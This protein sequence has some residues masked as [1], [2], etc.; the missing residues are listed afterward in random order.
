MTSREKRLGLR[1][2]QIGQHSELDIIQENMHVFIIYVVT[3]RQAV[4]E[5]GGSVWY[6]CVCVSGVWLVV[7]TVAIW[8]KNNV[9]LRW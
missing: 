6:V 3:Q 2:F 7:A 9:I 8:E 1:T 4:E 5:V